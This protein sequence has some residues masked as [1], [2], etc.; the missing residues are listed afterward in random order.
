VQLTHVRVTGS[1]TPL[2]QSQSREHG[3]PR[4]HALPQAAH[5]Q[6]QSIAC[7]PGSNIPLSHRSH[8]VGGRHVNE[9]ALQNDV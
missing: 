2:S 1:Q 4:G 8:V 7:S 6:P 3:S 5:E 9:V